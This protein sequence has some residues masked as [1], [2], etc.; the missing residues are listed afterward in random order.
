MRS[1]SLTCFFV[2][3]MDKSHLS[4]EI[5]PKRISADAGY[6]RAGKCADPGSDTGITAV[7][8]NRLPGHIT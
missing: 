3:A 4:Y 5:Y 8:G 6:G 2:P 1:S 7:D